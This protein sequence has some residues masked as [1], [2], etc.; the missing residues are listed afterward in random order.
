M[1]KKNDRLSVLS[2][3]EEEDLSKLSLK[4]RAKA[5]TGKPDDSDIRNITEL[6]RLYEASHPGLLR[7]MKQ[8]YDTQRAMNEYMPKPAIRGVTSDLIRPGFWLPK[9]LQEFMERYYPT[10]WTNQK[11]VEWFIKRFPVFKA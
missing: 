8:D 5:V 9:D 2:N 3:S 11:H 1:P 7:R 6:I 10:L 4:E